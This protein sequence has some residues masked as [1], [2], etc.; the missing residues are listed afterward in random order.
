MIRGKLART[1]KVFAIVFFLISSTLVCTAQNGNVLNFSI[2]NAPLVKLDTLGRPDTRLPML[3]MANAGLLNLDGATSGKIC[4]G[5][6][7]DH[8]ESV[9]SFL[10]TLESNN[11]I[12]AIKNGQLSGFISITPP[13]ILA[14]LPVE[15]AVRYNLL[16]PFEM[17]R[18]VDNRWRFSR[19]YIYDSKGNIIGTNTFSKP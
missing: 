3:F 19:I 15:Y 4:F 10:F 12:L 1:G 7:I 9:A 8:E 13:E 6:D 17:L 11:G 16:I 5:D 2:G 14:N 18:D